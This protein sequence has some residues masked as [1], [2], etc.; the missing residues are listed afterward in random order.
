MQCI[1]E[2]ER[3]WRERTATDELSS[4]CLLNKVE[5][6]NVEVYVHKHRKA[7]SPGFQFMQNLKTKFQRYKF[8]HSHPEWKRRRDSC[9]L[10][11]L[12]SGNTTKLDYHNTHHWTVN[13]IWSYSRNQRQKCTR[14]SSSPLF[15]ICECLNL[16]RWNLVLQILMNWNPG[17]VAF[18]CLCTYTS[19]LVFSTLFRRQ[20]DDNSSVAVLSLHVRS[21]S[22]MH[23]MFPRTSSCPSSSWG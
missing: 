4:F 7:T 5:K 23:C 11:P 2:K 3:T 21:F 13:P 18:L 19:T 1:C 22:Q 17:D 6:T 8:R 14:I 15:R 10:L 12:V 20:N 16:Y 9:T